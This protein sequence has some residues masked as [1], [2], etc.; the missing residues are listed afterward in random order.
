MFWKDCKYPL[1]G[2][3]LENRMSQKERNFSYIVI[4]RYIIRVFYAYSFWN[5]LKIQ[6]KLKSQIFLL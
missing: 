6:L 5:I 4:L 3:L 2:K 1:Y